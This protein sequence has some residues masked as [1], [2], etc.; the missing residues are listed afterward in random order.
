[1]DRENSII[2]RVKEAREESMLLPGLK[3]RK[4][5]IICSDRKQVSS[6]LGR[7]D[8]HVRYIDQKDGFVG[9]CVCPN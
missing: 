1:M 6:L 5:E 9:A 2:T 8:G 4:C 7:G 3:F